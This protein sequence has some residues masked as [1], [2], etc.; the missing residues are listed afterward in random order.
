MTPRPDRDGH[1]CRRAIPPEAIF[2]VAE[3]REMVV[4]HPLEQRLRLAHL[5]L[6]AAHPRNAEFGGRVER[7]A[8]HAAPV[9]GGGTHVTERAFDARL[10]CGEAARVGL[11]VDLDE[12]PGFELCAGRRV[13]K[14]D[15]CQPSVPV[16]HDREQRMREQVHRETALGADDPERVDQERH[17]VRDDHDD[18]VR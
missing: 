10:D 11:A 17:V 14:V 2:A 6:L 4:F 9:G 16:T 12:L 13:L 3:K 1:R 5:A 7:L 8:A 18:R 15:A